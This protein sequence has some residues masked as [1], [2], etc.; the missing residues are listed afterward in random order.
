MKVKKSLVIEKILHGKVLIY[1]TDTLYGLGCNALNKDSVQKVREIKGRDEKP[2]SVIAPSFDWIIDNFIYDYDIRKYLPGPFTLL[3]KKKDPDFLKHISLNDRIGV[4]IPNN[5]FTKLI[6]KAAVPF[7]TT[8]V[9]K[10]GEKP[11]IF[12]NE[13]PSEIINQVDSIIESEVPVSG[14]PS[15]LILDDKILERN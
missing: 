9:N 5:P 11:I 3:L 1:P 2:F 7:V 8:S 14:I 12:L 6:E 4:R 10:S 15:T 13:I